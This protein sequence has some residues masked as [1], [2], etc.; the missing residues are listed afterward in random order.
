[1]PFITVRPGGPPPEEDVEDGVYPVVLVELKDPRTIVTERHPAG[2]DII[3]WVFAIDDEAGDRVISG[4]TSPASGPKSKMFG[5][6][7]ALLGG[8][9]PEIGAEYNKQDLIGR[10]ALA[11]IQHNDAGYPRIQSLTAIPRQPG[12]TMPGAPAPAARPRPTAVPAQAPAQDVDDL[13]F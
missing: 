3:E 11:T 13:P 9:A 5:W 6:L 8:R 1:M 7:T 4:V 10:R 12:I 2:T